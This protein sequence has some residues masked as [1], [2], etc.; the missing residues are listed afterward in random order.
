MDLAT[1]VGLLGALGI[2]LSAIM[3]GGD[4]VMFVN[5]PSIL[6]VVGGTLFAVLIK[7]SLG[8]F[9]GSF[10]V[11]GQAFFNRTDD[12]TKLIEEGDVSKHCT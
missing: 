8:Q 11:A 9:L 12:Q 10:K 5:I 3:L 1:L 6:I 7:F 4:P 2:I